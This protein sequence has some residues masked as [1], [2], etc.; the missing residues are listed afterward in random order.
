VT[1]ASDRPADGNTLRA[2]GNELSGRRRAP[3]AMQR[4]GIAWRCVLRQRTIPGYDLRL[5]DEV[6]PGSRQRGHVQRLADMARGIGPIRMLVEE[7]AARCKIEQRSA[8]QQRQRAVHNSS[9]EN[10]FLRI[11]LSTLHLS[12]LDAR[13][14]GLV[15]NKTPLTGIGFL[16][17]ATNAA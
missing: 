14:N 10:H 11:H 15:A 17:L 13:T 2:Q 8:S 5:A 3:G 4:K 12:T 9:P 7:R 16:D 1:L 6:Q